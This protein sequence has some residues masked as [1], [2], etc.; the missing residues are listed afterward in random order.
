MILKTIHNMDLAATIRYVARGGAVFLGGNTIGMSSRELIQEFSLIHALKP[1]LTKPV[2]H[3]IG[4]FA[5]SDRLDDEKMLEIAVEA[6]KAQGYAMSLY[7]IWRHLDGATDHFHC[8]TSQVDI[9]GKSISQS[10]ERYT[11]KRT[12]RS[13]EREYDLQRV[14]NI[15]DRDPEVLLPLQQPPEPDGL[16]IELPSSTSITK[17]AL[18]RDL[19]E[20]LPACRTV[21][22]LARALH[23]RGIA[24]VPQIHAES[25]EVYGMGYRYESG[26]FQGSFMPGSALTGNFSASKLVN[27]HGLSFEPERDLPVIKNPKPHASP[28][29][30]AV[31]GVPKQ[32]RT[33]KGDR[34]N[35]KRQ[36][37]PSRCLTAPGTNPWVSGNESLYAQHQNEWRT[38]LG[39][40]FLAHPVFGATRDQFVG[41]S[42]LPPVR[43]SSGWLARNH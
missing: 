10:F 21:G 24:M 12:C 17:E 27:K 35:A 40:T 2:V 19:R 11:A 5:P 4:A 6:L 30:V 13:L 8:V 29:L 7:A 34:R 42:L 33:K 41:Q 15:R 36:R 3:L 18:S 37:K 39:S 22:D 31:P 38:R 14:S 32:R 16:D 23:L 25:G 26:P 1:N 43:T 28:A 9:R 20:A